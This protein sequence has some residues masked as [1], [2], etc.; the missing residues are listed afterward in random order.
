MTR[1]YL[2]LLAV[3]LVVLLAGAAAWMT[4][5]P[6][7]VTGQ[8][9]ALDQSPTLACRVFLDHLDTGTPIDVDTAYDIA[10]AWLGSGNADLDRAAR[11]LFD[12]TP[13]IMAAWPYIAAGCEATS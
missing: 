3:A 12:G 5:Q 13:D 8:A 9:V 2:A 7:Q 4:V 6:G 10:G 11:V 1:R